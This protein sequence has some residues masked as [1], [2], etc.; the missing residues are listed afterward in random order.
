VVF[1]K[2]CFEASQLLNP[3]PLVTQT[4]LFQQEISKHLL[5]TISVIHNPLMIFM[6]E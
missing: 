1:L 6:F 3:A 5:R 2:V 4:L